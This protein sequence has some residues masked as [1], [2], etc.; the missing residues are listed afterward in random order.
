MSEGLRLINSYKLLSTAV[1]A[2]L[3]GFDSFVIVWYA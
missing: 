1:N 3:L 2:I